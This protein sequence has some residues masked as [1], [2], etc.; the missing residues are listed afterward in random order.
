MKH[1][2]IWPVLRNNG[3]AIEILNGRRSISKAQAGRLADFF[4]VPIDLYTYLPEIA[5]PTSTLLN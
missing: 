1:M 4:R 5:I 3:A 2:D